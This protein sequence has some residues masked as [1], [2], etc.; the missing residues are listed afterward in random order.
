VVKEL[1]DPASGAKLGVVERR[2]GEVE[3]QS[4]QDKFS[5]AR[6]VTPMQAARGDLVR[7]VND[8]ALTLT[9]ELPRSESNGISLAIPASSAPALTM[10]TLRQTIQDFESVS[11]ANAAPILPIGAMPI[12]A[13][14][15]S[16]GP[17][18]SSNLG[19]GQANGV[20]SSV[21]TAG[22]SPS[23]LTTPQTLQRVLP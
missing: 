3:I 12:G 22:A 23:T 19:T 21:P 2:L 8:G 9:S 16:V 17:L 20:S 11:N 7:L 1:T 14:T 5:V 6:P 13:L 18:A 4:V 10:E 15:S